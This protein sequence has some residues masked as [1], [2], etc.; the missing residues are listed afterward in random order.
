MTCTHYQTTPVAQ[1]RDDSV[2]GGWVTLWVCDDCGEHGE[3]VPHEV[4]DERRD[5]EMTERHERVNQ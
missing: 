1:V 2:V 4:V 3:T 5:M